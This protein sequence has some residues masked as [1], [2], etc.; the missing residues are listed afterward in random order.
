MPKKFGESEN[1][2]IVN[3]L[4]ET[5]VE[6]FSKYGLKKTS[7]TTSLAKL[8]LPRE[9]STI[10]TIQRKNYTSTYSNLKKKKWQPT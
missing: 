4:K 7:K 5:G 3:K 10:S 6:L 8:E 1:Q 9:V 2:I